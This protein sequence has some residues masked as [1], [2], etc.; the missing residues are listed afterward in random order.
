MSSR[1]RKSVDV[2]T[3]W[4]GV[5]MSFC[6][7][8]AHRSLHLVLTLSNATSGDG[9]LAFGALLPTVSAGGMLLSVWDVFCNEAPGGRQSSCANF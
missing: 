7:C 2:R 3:N 1:V 8:G 4:H 6:V 9:T 5:S